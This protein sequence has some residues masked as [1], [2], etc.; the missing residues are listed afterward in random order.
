MNVL[1]LTLGNVADIT[2]NEIYPALL[3]EFQRNGHS[4]YVACC[5][6]KRLGLATECSVESGVHILRIKTGNITKT[7]LIEKGISTLTVGHVFQ[8]AIQRYFSGV[9]FDLILYSTPPI[10]FCSLISSLKRKHHAKTYLMLKDI[11]PQNAV[12][13][14]MFRR[15][16]PV[17][18][19]FSRQERKL[20]RISDIIGCMSPANVE[21]LRKNHPDIPAD[22][23][24]IC[25][26]AL[27]I[28]PP[29]P[30]NKTSLRRNFCIPENKTVFLFGGNIGKPQGIDFFIRCLLKEKNRENA[31]FA[32]AGSGTEFEMLKSAVR[33]NGLRNVLILDRLGTEKFSDLTACCDVGLIFLDYR[34]TIPNFPSRMLS[35]LQESKPVLAATDLATDIKDVIEQHKIGWWVPSNDADAFD[36][37][38]Q[39]VLSNPDS[40]EAFGR[41]GRTLFETEYDVSVV[42][43]SILKNVSEQ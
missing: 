35:Y 27:E 1:F 6:E 32:V 43:R 30:V 9:T 16:S 39:Q 23:L 20:Y 22:K 2:S 36:A 3:R 34:F 18:L 11:F 10:T 41:N 13:L 12:D 25:P 7:N 26:N 29:R 15:K 5:R 24:T 40:V 8:K 4:V 33:E 17:Y 14:D 38:V 42:Y 31:F 37:A 19:Y 21:F 28:K